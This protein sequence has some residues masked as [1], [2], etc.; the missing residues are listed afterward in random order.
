VTSLAQPLW[1]LALVLPAALVW[2]RYRRRA[3]E[4]SLSF[5]RLGAL[6]LVKRSPRV[7]LVTLL[8]GLRVL[9]IALGVV[10]MA[11]PQWGQRFEEVLTEGIDIMM[12]LDVSGSMR[13]EDFR[14]K[15][16]L[17]VAKEVFRRFIERRPHDRIGMTVFAGGALT[18][19]PLTLDHGVLDRLVDE[20]DFDSIDEDGTAVGM[21]LATALNRMRRS[22]AATRV[23]VLLTDGINNRGPV[24]P[25]TAA[26]LARA[27]GVR[28]YA[29]GVGTAGPVPF[30]ERSEFGLQYVMRE[31]PLDELSLAAIADHTGGFYF[32][33]TDAA[34]LSEAFKR[35]DALE[36]SEI[37]VREFHLNE[38][39]FQP[40]AV[41]AMLL[42]GLELLLRAGVLRRLP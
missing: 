14:P 30:P 42:V 22:Q 21:A 28:V 35:I 41:A 34:S 16:R 19:C 27:L 2:L 7:R 33:A 31:V 40:L 37:E 29:V 18:R 12:V 20:V 25:L 23:V 5:S 1:L 24:D 6:R 36:K 11:R 26:E 10:A 15:N 39:R 9:A 17:E 8:W 32:R 38:E 3:V 4:P 13:A